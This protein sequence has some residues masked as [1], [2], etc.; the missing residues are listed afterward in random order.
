[1]EFTYLGCCEKCHHCDDAF[2]FSDPCSRSKADK[3]LHFGASSTCNVDCNLDYGKHLMHVVHLGTGA[4]QIDT[5]TISGSTC[6]VDCNLDYGKH[7]MHVVHLGTGATQIDTSTISGEDTSKDSI[8]YQV[9]PSPTRL[10]ATD[11]RWLCNE[12]RSCPAYR[13]KQWRMVELTGKLHAV[14]LLL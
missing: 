8:K 10:K 7:L 3:P 14:A 4:T 6:N 5:S 9:L 2:G 13:V 1:M 12:Q 11:E